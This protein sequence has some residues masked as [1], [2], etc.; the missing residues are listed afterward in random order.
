MTDSDDRKPK[1]VDVDPDFVESIL[2]KEKEL[3]DRKYNRLM[4][5][6]AV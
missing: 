2:E 6:L 5:D 4:R 3:E 1:V